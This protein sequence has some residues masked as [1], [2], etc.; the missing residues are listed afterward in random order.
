MLHDVRYALRTLRR[1]PAFAV[2]AVLAWRSASAPTWPS[3]PSCMPCCCGRC[4]S[5][6]PTA[7]PILRSSTR[8]KGGTT[9]AS[10]AG[11]S[12]TGGARPHDRK[13][14][15]YSTVNGET[16]CGRSAAMLAGRGNAAGS[17]SL[18]RVLRCGRSRPLV[19]ETEAPPPCTLPRSSSA[20]ACGSAPS[21]APPTSSGRGHGRRT[22]AREI[23]GVMPRG[24][25][26]PEGP[27]RGR[28]CPSAR[29]RPGEIDNHY[30]VGRC[31]LA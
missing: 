19:R 20:T 2:S 28:A 1:S 25:A 24:F 12:L 14:V 31:P 3:S 21:A 9:G 4:R 17:P 6:E 22:L 23:I 13:P 30:H 5:G 29:C 15:V 16:R 27:M 18:S 8:P 10:L 7:G 26:F 11:R